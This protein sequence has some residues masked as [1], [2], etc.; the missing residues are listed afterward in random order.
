MTRWHRRWHFNTIATRFAITIVLAIV[1][2]IALEVLIGFTF[3]YVTQSKPAGGSLALGPLRLQRT[4][5]I[6]GRKC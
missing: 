3:A 4:A 2:G 6:T 5:A 1:L